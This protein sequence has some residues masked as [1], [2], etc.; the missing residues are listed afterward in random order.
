MD[1][2]KNV[3][4]GTLFSA[5]D[6]VVAVTGGGTGKSQSIKPSIL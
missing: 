5:K 6:L 4:L 1:V 3:D 2:T